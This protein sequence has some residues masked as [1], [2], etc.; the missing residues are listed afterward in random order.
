MKIIKHKQKSQEWLNW[1]RGYIMASEAASVLDI[2][3]YTSK[4]KCW[5]RKLG[6]V[7]EQETNWAMERGIALESVALDAFCEEFGIDMQ[8]ACVESSEYNFLAAS[9]DGISSCGKYILE[10]KANGKKNHDLAL[11]GE[12]PKYY[13][14][15]MQH[16][17]LVTGA[18]KCYYYSFDGEKGVCIEVLPDANFV[19]DYLPKARD[20]WKSIIFFEAPPLSQEDYKDMSGSLSFNDYSDQYKDCDVQLKA[21]ENKKDYLRKKIIELCGDEDC[22]GNG[23]KITKTTPKGQVQYKDI[24]ELKGVDLDKY[25]KSMTIVWTIRLEGK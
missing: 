14:S 2:S 11:Q 16:Q 24:P 4:Y 17:L 5:Q 7:K 21:L 12:I 22:S 19:K 20:F 9:L 13:V 23:I 25:R 10:I 8:P 1:R 18:E 3:P 6:I 15:Q